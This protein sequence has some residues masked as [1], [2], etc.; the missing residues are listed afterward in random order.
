MQVAYFMSSAEQLLHLWRT[1][2]VPVVVLPT[3]SVHDVLRYS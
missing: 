3:L 2:M 1:L